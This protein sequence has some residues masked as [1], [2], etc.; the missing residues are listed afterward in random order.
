MPAG[1]Q[2]LD[3]P[4]VSGGD[5]TRVERMGEDDKNAQSLTLLPARRATWRRKG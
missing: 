2:R 5:E 1:P 3:G 4:A